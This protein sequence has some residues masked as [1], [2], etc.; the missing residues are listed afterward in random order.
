MLF[1]SVHGP[2]GGLRV[3]E[4][5]EV[6]L[7][8]VIVHDAHADD[9]AHAFAVSRLDDTAMTHVPF[10]VFRSVSRPT[11]NDL[12]RG[13]VDEARAAAGG[14]MPGDRDLAALLAGSDTWTIETSE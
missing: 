10:G 9:P 14:G 1:R 6:G 3:A 5:A 7:D 12:V 8:A 2:D 13:Q 11:Y 4:V